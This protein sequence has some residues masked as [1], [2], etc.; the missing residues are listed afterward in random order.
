[1]QERIGDLLIRL[2][3]LRIP[4]WSNLVVVL[5]D[6]LI[7][8]IEGDRERSPGAAGSALESGVSP[9]QVVS[10]N[11]AVTPTAHTESIRIGDTH[12]DHV[13]DA[14]QQILHFIISPVSKDRA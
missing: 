5:N 6:V 8:T 12:L 13:I 1:M 14:G 3:R 10:E 11:A 2:P 7:G 9:N 4:W